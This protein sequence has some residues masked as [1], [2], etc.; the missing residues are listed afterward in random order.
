MINLLKTI[1]RASPLFPVIKGYKLQQEVKAWE[2]QGKTGPSPALVKRQNLKEV[3]QAQG[4]K[5]FVETGTFMGDTLAALAEDFD[6]LYSVEL[7]PALYER[8]CKRFAGVDKITLFF[9]D[10]GQV[11]GELLPKLKEP[12][13]FWLDGH[14]SAGETAKGDK[15]TPILEE[16]GHIFATEPKHV[17]V[18]DDARCFADEA[19]EPD[20]PT[21][22]RLRAFVAQRAPHLEMEVRDDAIFLSPKG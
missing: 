2:A 5:I 22:S 1:L 13:L 19:P 6:Q 10:S 15:E 21:L 8:A 20:Y 18:I 11:L 14:Y 3:A 7:A 12:A 9:G 16:L 4:T 17:I